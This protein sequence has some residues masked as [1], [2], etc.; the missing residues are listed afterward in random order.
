MKHREKSRSTG[1]AYAW[2]RSNILGL[3]AI[4]LALSGTAVAAN[5]ASNSNHAVSAKKKKVKRGPAGPPGAQGPQGIQGQQGV[6]GPG[7]TRL[8]FL[9][10]ELD[11]TTRTIATV[12]DLTLQA[13]CSD[14]AGVAAVSVSAQSPT[15]GGT[16]SAALE[17]TDTGGSPTFPVPAS[18]LA[19]PVAPAAS[20]VFSGTLTPLASNGVLTAFVQ[21]TYNNPADTQVATLQLVA[22]ANDLAGNCTIHGTAVPAT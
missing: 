7:A 10:P 9:E 15:S 22:V 13:K 21:G 16:L 20:V 12:G 11:N 17:K 5:V 14:P 6:A 3:V 2:V 4:F 18:Q 8:Q 19:V 1:S